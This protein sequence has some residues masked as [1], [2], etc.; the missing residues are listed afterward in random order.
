MAHRQVEVIS[1]HAAFSG[2]NTVRVGNRTL[3]AGTS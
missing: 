3:E 1:G 2:P